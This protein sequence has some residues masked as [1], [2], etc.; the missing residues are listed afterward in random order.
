MKKIIRKRPKIADILLL[1]RYSGTKN[2]MLNLLMSG[3]FPNRRFYP[4]TVKT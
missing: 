1:I 3:S 2:R 4:C